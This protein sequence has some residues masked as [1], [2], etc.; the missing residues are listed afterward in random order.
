MSA[1]DKV[2]RFMCGVR[3]EPVE[4]MYL[5]DEVDAARAEDEA[6]LELAKAKYQTLGN[7]LRYIAFVTCGDEDADPQLGVDR[8]KDAFERARQAEADAFIAGFSAGLS[9][10]TRGPIAD[11]QTWQQSKREP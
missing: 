4:W 3:G 1:W 11:Y 6:Q 5:C 10:S 2:K 9:N 8:L 7:M